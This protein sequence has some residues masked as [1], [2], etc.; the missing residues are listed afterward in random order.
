[1]EETQIHMESSPIT[2]VVLDEEKKNFM[3]FQKVLREEEEI[4]R[5]KSR[6]LWLQ[7]GDKN[8][9][10]FHRQAKVRLWKNKIS[11][12]KVEYGSSIKG[13]YQVKIVAKEHFEKLYQEY[14][15]RN[16]EAQENLV[17]NIPQVINE[18]D[19]EVLF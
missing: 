1:M 8:T 11:K 10:F 13:H 4:W 12:I 2:S 19:N 7:A 17:Q 15:K 16:I 14:G 5:L 9:K 3:E 18:K 6:S